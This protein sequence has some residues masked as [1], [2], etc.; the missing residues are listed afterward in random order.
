MLDAL[1]LRMTHHT[2]CCA[3]SAPNTALF[4]DTR[5]GVNGQTKTSS[6]LL[7]WVVDVATRTRKDPRVKN[8]TA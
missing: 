6:K 5:Y 2:A 8:A 3:G 7:Q 1:L 4:T